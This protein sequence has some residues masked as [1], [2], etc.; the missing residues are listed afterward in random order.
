MESHKVAFEDKWTAEDYAKFALTGEGAA[1]TA[2][3]LILGTL[4]QSLLT[5]WIASLNGIEV[6][7]LLHDLSIPTARDM[8]VWLAWSLP[9]VLGSG[10]AA[11]SKPDFVGNRGTLRLID[12]DEFFVQNTLLTLASVAFVRAYAQ[13]I[14]YQGIWLLA[15]LRGQGI[16]FAS[17]VVDGEV[18]W[19][20]VMGG[21][22]ASPAVISIPTAVAAAAVLETVW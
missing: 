6:G 20:S 3:G 15:F 5:S 13:G 4:I 12:N 18:G 1:T 14:A 2:V 16:D 8:G 9:Y 22:V 7:T 11:W 21:L 10:A 19:S 17:S